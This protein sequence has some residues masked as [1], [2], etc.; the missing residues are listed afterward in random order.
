MCGAL[1][2]LLAA[3][4]SVARMI[5]KGRDGRALQGDFGQGMATRATKTKRSRTQ[6]LGFLALRF[7]AS[8]PGLHKPPPK[9]SQH[10]PGLDFTRALHGFFFLEL[11]G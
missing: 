11:S 1:C 5:K 3:P 10:A 2:D 4:L 6:T 9:K 7:P 8:V